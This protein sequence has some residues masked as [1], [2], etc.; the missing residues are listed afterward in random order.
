MDAGRCLH[1]CDFV[2]DLEFATLQLSNF[3]VVSRRVRYGIGDLFLKSPMLGLEFNK[4]LLNR[5]GETASSKDRL[6]S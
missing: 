6:E 1:P 4:M 3:S 5:H 2:F